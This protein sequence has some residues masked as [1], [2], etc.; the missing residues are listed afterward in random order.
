MLSVTSSIL[1]LTGGSP[2]PLGSCTFTVPL[3][4]PAQA[5][6]GSYTNT[7]SDLLSLGIPIAP[8]ATDSLV[9]EPPLPGDFSGD[10]IVDL[11]D[12]ILSLKVVSGSTNG[13]PV[14]SGADT[15]TDGMIGLADAI[16]LLKDL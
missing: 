16:E 9:I 15:G 2:P 1:T 14:Y 12:A 3:E 8:P 4:I 6:P 10:G 13:I 7:T 5:V 11:T